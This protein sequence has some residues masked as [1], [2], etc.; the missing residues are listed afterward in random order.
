VRLASFAF[1][2]GSIG[3][4]AIFG[5]DDFS[6]G[7][8]A[9]GA[10]AGGS[11]GSGG[12]V[13]IAD[14]VRTCYEGP[15]ETLDVGTCLQGTQV[16]LADGSAF[17]PCEDQV[18]PAP[19]DCTTVADEDC[20]ALACGEVVWS[21]AAGD[22]VSH[23]AD[24]RVVGVAS[25]G[26]DAIAVGVFADTLRIGGAML[27]ATNLEDGFV[28]RFDDKGVVRWLAHIHGPDAQVPSAVAVDAAGNSYVVGS[29]KGTL[30]ID[31]TS[32]TANVEDAFVVKLDAAGTV[33]W[34]R[35]FGG[36]AED[37]A[38]GVA[39]DASE[40]PVVVGEFRGAF[41]VASL[42]AA[43]ADLFVARLGDDGEPLWAEQLGGMVTARADDVAIGPGAIAVA[44][45]V[46]G[47]TVV[48]GEPIA[49]VDEDAIALV[50]DGDGV[51][52]AHRWFPDAGDGSARAIAFAG[53][54]V[55]IGG[56]FA[57]SIDLGELMLTGDG[58]IDSFALQLDASLTSPR[59]HQGLVGGG[60]QRL[61]GIA[62][63]RDLEVSLVGSFTAGLD[64]GGGTLSTNGGADLFIAKLG[65]DGGHRF[66]VS[67]GDMSDEAALAVAVMPNRD[68]L[69]GGTF[70]GQLNFGSAQHVAQLVDGFVARF[71]P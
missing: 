9:G 15:E 30:Q 25:D 39:V 1:V 2:A 63:N 68:V 7:G 45:T 65:G 31:S 70:G 50:Y 38:H 23:M 12:A 14:E 42:N 43:N 27:T 5:V 3:C 33:V 52:T 64:V 21:R 66:S 18:L 58:T 71:G 10:S 28:A 56:T 22:E 35:L 46:T 16:C 13:C 26:E 44:A 48:N 11:G 55:V 59:W 19:D 49:A 47:N 32:L 67:F 41:G 62:V 8:P 24:Q 17:G 61:E 29:T 51:L 4:N 40:H 6:V 60:V 36:P 20:N 54:D 37:R 69:V 34:A 53:G 57:T